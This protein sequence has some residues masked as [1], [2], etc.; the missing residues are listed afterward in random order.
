MADL[1]AAPETKAPGATMTAK[2]PSYSEVFYGTTNGL[3]KGHWSDGTRGTEVS[4]VPP[5]SQILAAR[6]TVRKPVRPLIAT[7]KTVLADAIRDE[8]A[9]NLTDK[10]ISADV[11]PKKFPVTADNIAYPASGKRGSDNPLYAT[12]SQIYGKEVPMA[13]Q[14]PDRYFPSTNLFT[15]GF[16][17]TK[18]RY[19]GLTTAPTLSKVHVAL[20]EYY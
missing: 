10:V 3:Y 4:D 13:H 12:S 11:I 7:A 6:P 15:K 20:D 16:V 17:E 2:E 19:T 1:T 18:P 14:L 5:I 8:R 9:N